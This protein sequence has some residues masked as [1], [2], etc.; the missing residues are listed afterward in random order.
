M[1]AGTQ[2]ICLLSRGFLLQAWQEHIL[3]QDTA[4]LKAF[5]KS[6]MALTMTDLLEN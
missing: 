3:D 1:Q 5:N 2:H 4:T 6:N